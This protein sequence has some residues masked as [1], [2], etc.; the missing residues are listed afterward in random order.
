MLT[1][2][3]SSWPGSRESLTVDG[4]DDDNDDDDVANSARVD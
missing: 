1:E 2:I 3:D 4:D